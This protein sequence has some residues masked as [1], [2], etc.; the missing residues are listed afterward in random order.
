MLVVGLV[1]VCVWVV[2]AVGANPD[3]VGM[4][5]V[6]VTP[7]SLCNGSRDQPSGMVTPGGRSALPAGMAAVL[8]R[9]PCRCMCGIVNGAGG[10]TPIVGA[11][12]PTN[13]AP[14]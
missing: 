10:R 14:P 1:K 11:M 7:S 8:E 13:V 9:A 12:D 6:C 3:V 2:V 5:P 4:A